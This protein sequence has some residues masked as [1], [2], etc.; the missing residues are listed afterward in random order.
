MPML[1]V[2]V[3]LRAVERTAASATS[4]TRRA[5]CAAAASAVGL[6]TQH[7]ELVAA[8]A[9]EQCRLAHAAPGCAR[10][11]LEQHAV[12]DVVAQGVVD[13]A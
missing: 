12:A 9:R 2:T 3:K 4:S 13:V 1:Q 11:T 10:A 6:S 7:D 5:R 8:Q